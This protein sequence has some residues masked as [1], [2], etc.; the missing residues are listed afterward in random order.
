MRID[1]NVNNIPF[2]MTLRTKN[3][4]LRISFKQF[5]TNDYIYVDLVNEDGYYLLENERL[6][7]GRPVAIY[8]TKDENNN[9]SDEFPQAYITPMTITGE[10]LPVTLSNLGKSVFLEYYELDSEG[11]VIINE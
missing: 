1:V 2:E 11:Q 10:E 3:A 7:V 5:M 8:F 9:V 6:F 4:N